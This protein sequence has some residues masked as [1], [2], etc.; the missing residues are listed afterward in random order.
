[1]RGISIRLDQDNRLLPL[2]ITVVPGLRMPT[3]ESAINISS[4]SIRNTD[5]EEYIDSARSKCRWDR[6]A[7]FAV[8]V[9]SS[10]DDVDHVLAFGIPLMDGGFRG[11]KAQQGGVCCV[12]DSERPSDVEEVGTCHST[13]AERLYCNERLGCFVELENRSTNDESVRVFQLNENGSIDSFLVEVELAGEVLESVAMGLR[14]W[15]EEKSKYT[16]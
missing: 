4:M 14:G 8:Y 12:V 13:V 16:E 10:I 7:H 3:C 9:D 11:R 5:W 1:M 6:R 15:E 2:L